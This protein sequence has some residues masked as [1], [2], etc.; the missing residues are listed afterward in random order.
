MSA[1]KTE[2]VAKQ[3]A[4]KKHG[5]NWAEKYSVLEGEDGFEIVE[6]LPET[7]PDSANS[8]PEKLAE[9]G[10]QTDPE[11][12]EEEAP[13]NGG[14]CSALF[15]AMINPPAVVPEPAA[16][17]TAAEKT[18]KVV[19]QNRPEQNGLKRPSKGSTCAIIW[20]TCDRITSE[21]SATCTSAQLFNALQ[22]YNDCTLRTQ[23]ARWRQ[24]NGITG[25]LPGQNK[26]ATKLPAEFDD[27]LDGLSARIAEDKVEVL[28]SL[29]ACKSPAE[30]VVWMSKNFI[31]F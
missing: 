5:K 26:V 10:N 8:E 23:Y 11:L 3:Q 27:V 17:K 20:D 6:K 16:Q 19:E 2:A 21:S 22:G 9:T 24:F 28:E 14:V 7:A 1:Y 29:K 4:S 13:H 30:L 31:N 25:R 15:G 12:P 18:G